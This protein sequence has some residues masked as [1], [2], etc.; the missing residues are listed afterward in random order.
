MKKLRRCVDCII[1]QTN[2]VRESSEC[3][4]FRNLFIIY[5]KAIVFHVI[6]DESVTDRK[7]QAL[8]RVVV[9]YEHHVV[10]HLVDSTIFDGFPDYI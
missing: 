1:A 6:V 10:F 3:C 4:L 2:I 8:E 9:D 7:R 5:N